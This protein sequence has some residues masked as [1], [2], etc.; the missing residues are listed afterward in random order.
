MPWHARLRLD[1]SREGGRTVARHAHEGPL[2]I[3]QTL[4][5]EGDA[6][7]HNVL[8]HPPSGLVGGDTLDIAVHVREGS[9]GFVTTPGAA[10]FYRSEGEP[11]MQRAHLRLDTGARLEWLPLEA[12]AYSGCIA[13]NRIELDLAP[14]AEMMGWDIAALGLPAAE[15]PFKQGLL[16]QH[17]ELEGQW[18]ERGRIDAND[19]RLMDGPLGL[20]GRRCLATL[21]FASGSDI[22]DARREQALEL[23]NEA[24]AA[25]DAVVS[26]GATAPG[27]RVIVVRVL[28]DVV[29]PAMNL[30]KAIHAA[31]RPALWDQPAIASRLWAL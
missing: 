4:Y 23:A 18:L 11:A 1:Y 29:E 22:A 8:V 9:H 6:I 31:W 14:G 2:R 26:A 15:Q 16:L 25:C 30:L 7:A 27:P 20:A 28:A 10:R 3:L 13:E 12:L 24:L 17:L 5:P 21:F 19:A